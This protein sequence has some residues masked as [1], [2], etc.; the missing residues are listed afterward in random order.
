MEEKLLAHQPPC[1]ARVQ[2]CYELGLEAARPATLSKCASRLGVRSPATG[3]LV[4]CWCPSQAE[5]FGSPPLQ[6]LPRPPGPRFT[7]GSRGKKARCQ[8]GPRSASLKCGG[9]SLRASCRGP[10]GVP[11]GLGSEPAASRVVGGRG[12]AGLNH[13]L[14]VT[15]PQGCAVGVRGGPR[16]SRGAARPWESAVC[17]EWRGSGGTPS[18][19]GTK[20]GILVEFRQGCWKRSWEGV[21]MFRC[22]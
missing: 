17:S 10:L 3:D 22:G 11:V 19:E 8:T 20:P 6:L 1:L 2:S 7:E 18:R 16:P 21:S 9:A 5:R 4:P 13:P 15:E 12:S 14:S